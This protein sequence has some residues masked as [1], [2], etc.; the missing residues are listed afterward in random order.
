V[1]DVCNI[2]LAKLHRAARILAEAKSLITFW[3]MGVNQ[4]VAGTFTSN[5]IINLHL[6]TGQIGRP[7]CGPFSL[8]GQPNAM[9]GRDTG[10]MSHQLPGQR[11]IANPEHRAQMERFWNLPAGHLQPHPGYDTVRIFDAAANGEI[12]AIWIIGTNPAASLPNLKNVRAGLEAADLVIVQDA[13]HPTETTRYAHVLL[14]AAVNLEQA[15]TFCNSERRVTFMQQVV[16]PPGDARPDWWWVQQVAQAMGLSKGMTFGSAADI[17]DEFARSTAGRPNDQSALHHALLRE[18]GPQFWPS[19]AMGV[20]QA[21]RYADGA[22]PTPSGRAR[23]FAR[24]HVEA[25]ERPSRAFPLILTTGRVLN[26]W[27]SRTKTGLVAAL[28]RLDPAPYLQMH[29]DDAARLGLHDRQQV[30]VTSRFGSANTFLRL[31]ADISPGVVF[32]PIHWNDLWARGASCNESTSN[33]RDPVSKQPSLKAVAVN[34][35]AVGVAARVEESVRG[36]RV[37]LPVL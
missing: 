35:T 11:M 9:G 5:A 31:D 13:Y 30:N 16:Q 2:E 36:E 14:P 17:F 12:K 15:G 25:D 22:F 33:V 28:N 18:R 19:P 37:R 20:P 23:F 3:T 24:Q 4:T 7:G 1:V 21:R 10:Y 32:M 29:P 27:H 6:A 8:T 26:Q 34:V